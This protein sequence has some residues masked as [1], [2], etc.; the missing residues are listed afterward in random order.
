MCNLFIHGLT[1][2]L[3]PYSQDSEQQ[4]PFLM[5]RAIHSSCTFVNAH[6]NHSWAQGSM[7][8]FVMLQWLVR[9]CISFQGNLFSY[10]LRY[11]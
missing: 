11:E 6:A 10:K 8:H 3:E 1:Y 2:M 5:G 9:V 4:N 7:I